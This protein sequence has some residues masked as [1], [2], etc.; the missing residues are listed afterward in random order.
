MQSMTGTAQFILLNYNVNVR[1]FDY[2]IV[3]QINDKIMHVL[4]L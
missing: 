2:V 3:T 1:V 4:F